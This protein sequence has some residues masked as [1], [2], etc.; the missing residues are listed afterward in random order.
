MTE[1]IY[2]GPQSLETIECRI[3][4][5]ERAFFHYHP[6]GEVSK[7]HEFWNETTLEKYCG[8]FT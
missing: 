8:V 7:V 4:T 6:I 5:L 2:M 1:M 3:A